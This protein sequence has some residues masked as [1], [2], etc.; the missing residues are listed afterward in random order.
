MASHRITSSAHTPSCALNNHCPRSRASRKHTRVLA[1]RSALLHRSSGGGGLYAPAGAAT[2]V[3][4]HAQRAMLVPVS[5]DAVSQCLL[6]DEYPLHHIRHR[7]IFRKPARA[8]GYC[9]RYRA[10]TTP[11]PRHVRIPKPPEHTRITGPPA[12]SLVTPPRRAAAQKNP[13]PP[14]E[15]L[16]SQAA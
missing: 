8:R 16:H 9:D 15:C 5:E 13:P 7:H 6:M 4:Q 12:E 11:S 10:R 3:N 1:E 2:S 14:G